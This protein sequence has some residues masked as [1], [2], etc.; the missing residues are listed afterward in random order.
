[1]KNVFNA[2]IFASLFVSNAVLAHVDLKSSTPS[3]DAVLMESPKELSLAFSGDVRLINVVL[4]GEQGAPI[5]FGFQPSGES[6]SQK[7]WDLPNL[8]TG[9]YS[10]KMT[11]FGND[12][13]KMKDGFSFTVQ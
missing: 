10:V 8:A 5:E 2:F 12:G 4:L 1:M 11:F 9:S 7:A 13:H 6:L 3:A